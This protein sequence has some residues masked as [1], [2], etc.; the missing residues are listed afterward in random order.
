M[1]NPILRIATRQKSIKKRLAAV[2][3]DANPNPYS[4]INLLSLKGWMLREWKP[5]IPE[6]KGGGVFR[7]SPLVDGRKLAYRKMD[8]VYDSFSLVGSNDDQDLMIASIQDLQRLLEK[9]ISYW[10]TNWQNQPVWI[11]AKASN[12]TN[13]RYAVIVDYRFNGFGGP[14]EQPF[15][16][17]CESATEALLTIEHTIW[18][19]TEPGSEGECVEVSGEY[20]SEEIET[21]ATD[22]FYPGQSSDDATFQ[23]VQDTPSDVGD[24]TNVNIGV[25]YQN[26]LDYNCQ[27]G[28]AFDNVTIPRDA[29]ILKA[30]ITLTAGSISVGTAD[31]QIQVQDPADGDAATFSTPTDFFGRTRLDDRVTV[32]LED[33]VYPD[34]IDVTELVQAVVKDTRSYSADHW[35]SGDKMAFFISLL[36][37]SGGREFVAFDNGSN[38]AQLDIEYSDTGAWEGVPATCNHEVVVANKQSKYVITDVYIWD[39]SGLTFLDDGA[40]E[41]V[42]IWDLPHNLLP[43]TPAVGDILYIGSDTSHSDGGVFNNV[44]FNLSSSQTGIALGVWKYWNGASWHAF[45][46]NGGTVNE[47]CGDAVLF[48]STGISSIVFDPQDDW[49]EVAVNGV[50]GY[51]IMFEITNITGVPTPPVEQVRHIYTSINPYID[52]D[53]E[54]VPGDIPALARILFDGLGCYYRSMNTLIMGIRSMLRGS[55]FNA[56][57]NASDVQ[58]ARVA[59]EYNATAAGY[60]DEPRAPTGK[61]LHL[62]GITTSDAWTNACTW[63]ISGSLAGEYI[64]TYHAFLRFYDGISSEG[65][66]RYRLKSV[67]GSEYN[68][69][70]S[71]IGS[72]ITG[73]SVVQYCLD[74]GQFVIQP[75]MTIRMNDKVAYVKIMLETRSDDDN[76][77][78]YN[79]IYDIVL[80]PSDEWSGN[81]GVPLASGVSTLFYGRGLDVDGITNPRQYRATEN[82]IDLK[83]LTYDDDHRTVL[84][85]WSRTASSEPIFQNNSDQR[86]WFLQTKKESTNLSFFENCGKI[87]AQRSARYIFAR[88]SK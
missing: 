8:N 43:S 67:F 38:Y 84:A 60:E 53:E 85:E 54:Q 70:Y 62:H 75:S 81:F 42:M 13:I 41:N 29:H 39:D 36:S 44:N 69:S 80:I 34:P 28:I 18:Q 1:S 30:T 51:W 17:G 14:F 3:D 16:S 79:S 2:Y 59:F 87:C 64:G 24:L 50:T 45:D 48:D 15:F 20:Y 63:T 40:V 6:P 31:L 68:V 32:F 47:L 22:T 83:A 12:E 61:Y 76:L 65:H 33:G 23:A 11:E 78:V 27:C 19:E 9:A 46:V 52:I 56:Y 71:D 66:I 72:P 73:A 25:G 35:A 77:Y 5:A 88:G 58:P 82:N 49:T 55:N 74:L 10:T 37:G 57:L 4:Y 26:V 7:N 86:I 21:Y